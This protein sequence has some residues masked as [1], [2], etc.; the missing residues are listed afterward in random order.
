MNKR[1]LHTLNCKAKK[2]TVESKKKNFQYQKDFLEYLHSLEKFSSKKSP[3]QQSLNTTEIKRVETYQSSYLGRITSNLADTLFEECTNI[4]GRELVSKVLAGFFKSSPPTAANLI[5]APN[6]ISDHLR[7]STHSKEYLL[8]ADLAEICIK[9]WAILTG[10]DPKSCLPSANSSFSDLFLLPTTDFLKPCSQHDLY[11]CW[12]QSQTQSDEIPEEIFKQQC[13]VLLAK[14]SPTLILVIAVPTELYPLAESMIQGSSLEQA[15][16]NLTLCESDIS[17]QSLAKALQ[18]F[19][20]TLAGSHVLTA[21]PITE[22][23]GDSPR[24]HTD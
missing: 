12:N 17:Q 15:I 20:A 19:I 10:P 22:V 11:L 21:V 3:L 4:F 18:S 6:M 24:V 9:R 16:E 13:G 2:M 7:S 23:K 1:Q 8:F 5:D 14:T